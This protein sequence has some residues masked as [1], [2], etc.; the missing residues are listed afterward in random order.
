MSE[1]KSWVPLLDDNASRTRADE[2]IDAI[3][4]DLRD[5][6]P[7]AVSA[8]LAA[9][10]AG[11]ALFFAYLGF[12]RNDDSASAEAER[13][14]DHAAEGLGRLA[15]ASLYSGGAGVAWAVTHLCDDEA[16]V[17]V[18]AP[19]DAALEK[20]FAT[21]V[22]TRDYDLIS[23][24]VGAGLYL[25]AAPPSVSRTA[26]LR[27]IVDELEATA[28]PANDGV[29][30]FTAP[31]LLP[32]WQRA[33]APNGYVNLGLAHG[34]PGVIGLLARMLT[35]GIEP[36]RTRTLLERAMTWMQAAALTGTHSRF[37]TWSGESLPSHPSRL[38]W[39]YGDLGIAP[40]FLM[41]ARA[42][43]RDDWHAE[44][45]TMWQLAAARDPATAGIEDGAICH[46]AGGIAHLFAR[47][48]H[49]TG[50]GLL[51]DA[52]RYWYRKL[53]DFRQPDTGIG[54][55]LALAREA[56]RSWFEA[57]AGVLEGSAGIGLAL[58]A[59]TAPIAPD[60]DHHLMADVS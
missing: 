48:H 42:A 22:A 39:C 28:R 43:G 17:R 37:S 36:T 7:T 60:W 50:D 25:L 13:W 34:V 23:G 41:A 12:A 35:A 18:C 19:V 45:R 29:M 9:G 26:H 51:A 15:T 46:G 1:P 49:A 5:L 38:G 6:D 30:W 52:A 47:L 11:I 31:E 3:A 53:L 21:P 59:A 32:P 20:W 16:A 8:S 44:A 4:S 40:V 10:A 2:A 14:I 57:K 55:F 58:L 27:T 24:T 33:L 56:D 54:G